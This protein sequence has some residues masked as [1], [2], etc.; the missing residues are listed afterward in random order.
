MSTFWTGGLVSREFWLSI[1]LFLNSTSPLNQSV[2]FNVVAARFVQEKPDL[3]KIEDL[4][5]MIVCIYA[6]GVISHLL[7]TSHSD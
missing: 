2:E 6:K 1:C 3:H 7:Q 5:R 4:S